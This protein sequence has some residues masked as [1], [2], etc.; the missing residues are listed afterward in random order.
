MEI[1]NE[2]NLVSSH[3]EAHG[4]EDHLRFGIRVTLAESD[5]FR[6]LVADNWEKFH[7]YADA[8]TRDRA[9]ADMAARHRYSRLGD[10]PSVRYEPIDR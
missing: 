8:N 2:H 3:D 9:L 6:R 4:H 7:W 1:S 5:P 10:E